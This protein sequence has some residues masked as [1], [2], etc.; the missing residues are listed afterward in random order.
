AVRWPRPAFAAE[1]TFT[2]TLLHS[3][4]ANLDSPWGV[5][6][7]AA[8]LVYVTE[9]RLNRVVRQKRDGSE[10]RVLVGDG[11]A[12]GKVRGPRGIAVDATGEIYVVDS[13]NRRVQ[14]FGPDGA[15]RRAWGGEGTGPG[16]F[17]APGG[18]AV[19]DD[20]H[21][22]VADVFNDRIQK[23][24]TAGQFVTAWGAHGSDPGQFSSPTDVALSPTG[25]VFV[26]DTFRNRIQACKPDGSS[27][28]IFAGKDLVRNPIGIAVDLAER[29]Y[30][31]EEVDHRVKV[32]DPDGTV[33]G[34][35]GSEGR[36]AAAFHFPQDVAVDQDGVVYVADNF[37]A[38]VQIFQ[39][40]LL[41]FAPPR[42]AAD[43][44]VGIALQTPF[45]S[46]LPHNVVDLRVRLDKKLWTVEF[47]SFYDATGGLRRWGW[48]ISEPLR[49][50]VSTTITQYFQRGVMDWSPDGKGAHA[51]LPRPVWDFLGGG[52]GGAPNLG[53]EPLLKSTQPGEIVGTWDH[54][55]SNLAVDGATVGFKDFFDLLGGVKLVGA[56]R[57]EARLDTGEPGTV[58]DRTAEP[59]L[60]RQYFQNAVFEPSFSESP[61]V[62]LRLLGDQLR[63]RLYPGGLWQTLDPF[64]GAAAVTRGARVT[65]PQVSPTPPT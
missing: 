28:R 18:I 61:P 54:R 11:T 25:E 57:T 9:R 3:L 51:V 26:T 62:R 19:S 22:Y 4:F 33:I 8:G 47:R 20:G 27:P 35:F 31:T 49:E 13:R 32:F 16:Q 23:F 43:L 38:R 65:I 10:A 39:S 37:N 17:N 64:K 52:R 45:A 29:V 14:V 55:V 40:S 34:T 12:P 56:P 30:V 6:V 46:P 2:L 50:S 42:E 21:V 1:E 63:D 5:A 7:D 36:G 53:V 48:P 58:F 59:G 15:V 41:P 44:T 60:I 24:T